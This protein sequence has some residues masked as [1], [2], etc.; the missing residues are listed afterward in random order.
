MRN[1]YIYKHSKALGLC[2]LSNKRTI[3]LDVFI[4]KFNFFKKNLQNL[5]K[6]LFRKFR[7]KPKIALSQKEK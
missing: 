5:F 6:N 2:I 7:N 4:Q 3:S 1:I